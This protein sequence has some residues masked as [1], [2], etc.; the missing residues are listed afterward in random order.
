MGRL[1][2]FTAG[3]NAE[4]VGEVTMGVRKFFDQLLRTNR[5]SGP[6]P[7]GICLWQDVK[8]LEQL[9]Q[10]LAAEAMQRESDDWETLQQELQRKSTDA[11]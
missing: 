2:G 1:G 5:G 8:Q 7:S 9:T 6:K 11:R 10:D 3:A 4:G